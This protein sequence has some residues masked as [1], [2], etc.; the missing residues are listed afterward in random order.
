[1]QCG[2]SAAEA[3][4]SGYEQSG[5]GG[6]DGGAGAA[7]NPGG[8]QQCGLG[9]D[10]QC[11]PSG[12]GGPGGGRAT[13]PG[14]QELLHEAEDLHSNTSV[15][16]RPTRPTCSGVSVDCG[17]GL[18]APPAPGA[19]W[20][21][22]AALLLLAVL[23]AVLLLAEVIVVF[24]VAIVAGL[25]G[26]WVMTPPPA[27]DPTSPELSSPSPDPLSSP[28]PSSCWAVTITSIASTR[29]PRMPRPLSHD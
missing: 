6:A 10:R 25:A 13:E 1:M 5:G 12:H 9:S 19:T 17:P 3:R 22:G 21:A 20:L 24:V 26:G 23:L 29:L 14:E 4:H 11:R 15:P 28:D 18:P 7:R 27:A 2:N 8:T 16:L